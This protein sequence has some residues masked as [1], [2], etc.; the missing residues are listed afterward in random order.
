M[1]MRGGP[2]DIATALDAH[3]ITPLTPEQASNKPQTAEKLAYLIEQE[4]LAHD[5]YQAMYDK[6]GARSKAA[7]AIL[8]KYDFTNVV[9]GINKD[10][11]EAKHL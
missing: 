11:V 8:E 7:K 9:N 3:G 10:H 2:R 5:T 4:K 6:W 1:Q